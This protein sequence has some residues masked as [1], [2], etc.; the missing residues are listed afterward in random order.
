MKLSLACLL[1]IL[2]VGFASAADLT[3]HWPGQAELTTPDG[4]V[5][6]Q[7]AYLDLKQEGTKVT[8]SGGTDQGESLPLED[9]QFDGKTL[10]FKV[11]GPDGRTYKSSLALVSADQLE[12][13]L[14]FTM[15]D[16]TAVAAKL[17]LKREP[18]K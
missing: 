7:G 10:T 16:G 9:V 8:G 14:E 18:A 13:K 2:L 11:S 15:E 6:N 3:G 1:T 4:A 17:T 5:H 12:G